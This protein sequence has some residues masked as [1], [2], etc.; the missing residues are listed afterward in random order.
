MPSKN[1]GKTYAKCVICGRKTLKS[2]RQE[3]PYRLRRYSSEPLSATYPAD[4]PIC[5]RHTIEPAELELRFEHLRAHC[6]LRIRPGEGTFGYHNEPITVEGVRCMDQRPPDWSIESDWMK[7]GATPEGF[8][9]CNLVTCPR[10]DRRPSEP[11]M[12]AHAA[13]GERGARRT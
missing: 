6:D 1:A 8:G 4:A 9:H 11:M 2:L 10:L 3:W 7:R 12:E 13:P 5:G